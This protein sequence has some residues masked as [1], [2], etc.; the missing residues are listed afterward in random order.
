MRDAFESEGLDAFAYG[1]LCYDE[2]PAEYEDVTE[3]REFVTTD[4]EGVEH[5]AKRFVPT[6]ERRLIAEAGNR[7]GI[8]YE[9]AL[10][11]ECAYLRSILG[12]RQP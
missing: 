8:R 1:L 6:G 11:L 5:V 2:W 10:A 3:E 9:E 12:G 4:D 7:Y